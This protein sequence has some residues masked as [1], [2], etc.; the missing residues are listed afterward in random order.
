[1]GQTEWTSFRVRKSTAAAIRAE[2][3]KLA[4]DYQEGRRKRLPGGSDGLPSID[5]VI[6]DLLADRLAHRERSKKASRTRRTQRM[7][8]ADA[9]AKGKPPSAS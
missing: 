4:G 8:A 6:M 5:D 2:L 7:Q 9:S 1:M 3:V